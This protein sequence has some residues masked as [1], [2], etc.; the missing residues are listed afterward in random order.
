MKSTVD[1]ELTIG[2]LAGHFDL[3]PHVLRHWESVGLLV[4]ARR[5]NG[6]RRYGRDHLTRVAVIVHGK[7]VGLGLAELRAILTS[8]DGTGRRDVLK[9]HRDALDRH[10]A[11]AQASRRLVDHAISCDAED[12][13]YCPNFQRLVHDVS[14]P[15]CRQAAGAEAGPPLPLPHRAS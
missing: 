4:P 9:R 5:V 15:T 2:E 14:D 10:I 11:Q 7:Q 3:A 8:A 12:F 6:R 1:A 13:M